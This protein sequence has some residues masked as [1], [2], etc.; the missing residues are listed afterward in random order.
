MRIPEIVLAGS[1]Y[2]KGLIHGRECRAQLM[3]S[4]ETYRHRYYVSKKIT[5]EDARLIARRFSGLFTGEYARYAEEMKGI[6]QGGGL[7]FEDVLALNLRSEILY[8]GIAKPGEADGECTAFSAVFPAAKDGHALAGQTWDFTRA[9]R[10]ASLM[11]RVPAEGDTPAM[12]MLLEGGM[13]GGKGIN[14]AGISLTLNALTTKKT[15]TGIPLHVRMRRV[16]EAGS[17]SAAY[18]RATVTPIPVP[19]NLII[20]HKDGL[21][22][23]LE[24]DPEGVD[25]I[26]PENGV[27]VH[28]NHYIGPRMRLSHAHAGAGSTY[29]RFQRMRQLMYSK[30]SLT[31]QDLELF[32]RDHKGWPT[33]I[34]VHPEPGT[35]PEKLP[36]SGSTNQAF[37]TDLTLGRFRFVMGNPCEGEF[38]DYSL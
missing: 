9:Q 36:Y 38:E 20:T 21:S 6:A 29:M 4:L 32:C 11:A 10:E 7:E 33:S 35:P 22:L 1:P 18:S 26:Q 8:S 31:L 2:E 37:V 5:W 27:I 15:D 17:L 12:L 19:V 25:V 34:C 13:V 16:L 30:Q 14:G 24:M 23:C 3:R 28:T